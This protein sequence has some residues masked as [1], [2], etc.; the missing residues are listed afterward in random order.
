MIRVVLDTN[1]LVSAVIT[2]TGPN[3]QILEL[4]IAE[5]IRP[6]MT[7]A[8]LTE[9]NQVFKYERLKHLDRRLLARLWRLLKSS[10][11]MVKSG[12][13]LRISGHEEDNRIYECAVAA[14]AQYIVTENAK[15]FRHPYKMT[16]VVTARQLLNV[17]QV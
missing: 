10:G 15:H 9:Y 1:V 16:K 12:G 13:R 4:I 6:Y 5:R 2:P 8:V 11:V 17:L 7:E 14:K 3:A